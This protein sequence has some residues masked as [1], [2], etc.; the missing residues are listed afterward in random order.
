MA[1]RWRKTGKHL[2]GAT[3]LTTLLR[4]EVLH[5]LGARDDAVT[6]LRRH[7]VQQR[8]TLPHTLL[9]GRGEIVE[10]GLFL[11]G[12]YPLRLRLTAVLI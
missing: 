9:R 4:G 10:T 11:Q 7:V 1:A 3:N 5:H 8:K 12:L 6:L 2:H